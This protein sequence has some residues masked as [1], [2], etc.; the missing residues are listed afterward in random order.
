[1]KKHLSIL[2]LLAALVV[3]WASR[4]QET[5]TVCDGTG[6]NT[7]FPVNGLYTDTYAACNEFII[8]AS[9]LTEMSGATIE[10]MTFYLST[11]A[12]AAW[13]GTIQ[14][15]LGETTA[16]SVASFSTP[17]SSAVTVV[18][19]GLLDATGTTMTVTFSTPYEYNGGNLLIGSY[20]SVAGNYKL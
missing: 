5:L 19:T 18:Y 12:A 6:T 14:M 7:H 11:P 10:S 3:P 16:T 2:M 17:S 9:L 8:P 4:A 1:M 15:Y 20:I 13:T